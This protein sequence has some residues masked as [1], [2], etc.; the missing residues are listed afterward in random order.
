MRARTMSCSPTRRAL[1]HCAAAALCLLAPGARAQPDGLGHLTLNICEDENEWP[2]YAYFERVNGQ[3]TERVLG[4]AVSVIDDIL[5]RRHI[6]YQ[7]D[8]IPWARCLAVAKL[9]KRYQMALNMSYNAERAADFLFSR[10]Y[11]STTTYY[12]YSRRQ[13]PHGLGI[14]HLADFDR[15]R[16]CGI[17][18]YNYTG[19]GFKAGQV[20]QGAKDFPALIAKLQM[21]RCALFVEKNEVMTGYATIGKDYLA[22]PDIAQESAPNMK[23]GRFYFAVSRAYPQAEA[24]RTLLNDELLSMQESGRLREL[25]QHSVPS[26]GKSDP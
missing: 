19:Y 24:L 26:A 15:Y 7:L 14:K 3:K 20:E 23:S 10:A 16:I 12:Y 6:A 9:G 18:G 8:M 5:K 1:L 17:A 2:P 11:Y 22:D 21:G 13:Y 4:Y 25:W